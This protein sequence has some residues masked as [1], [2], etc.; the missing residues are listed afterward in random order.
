MKRFRLERGAWGIAILS[1]G[2]AGAAT[3][4]EAPKLRPPKPEMVPGFWEQNRGLL[5]L[6]IIALVA[7]AVL[8]VALLRRSRPFAETAPEIIARRAL[9]GVRTRAEDA[10]SVGEAA[11]ILR[12]HVLFALGLP[13]GELTTAEVRRALREGLSGE[14]DLAAAIVAFFERCDAWN[15][16]P[17]PPPGRISAAN[18]AL[19]LLD[20][21]EAWRK[22][23]LPAPVGAGQ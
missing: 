12:G 20:R 3:T 17:A 18:E 11:R 14:T 23:P 9:E 19:A 16:A 7:A 22:R 1:A 8:V 15:F 5:W 4:E 21:I 2:A 13:P 6:S 10:R